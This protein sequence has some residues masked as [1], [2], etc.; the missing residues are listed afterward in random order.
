MLLKHEE[1]MQDAYRWAEPL[2]PR[3][4]RAPRPLRVLSPCCG[5]NGPGRAIDALEVP[6]ASAGDYD[7]SF[8]LYKYL[9]QWIPFSSIGCGR[10]AGDVLDIPLD[11]LALD[12]DALI[13]GPPCPPFSCIGKI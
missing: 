8:F 3:I 12:I 7:V 5:L 10:V 2:R 13:S 6:W 1:Q 11:H 9:S 4:K